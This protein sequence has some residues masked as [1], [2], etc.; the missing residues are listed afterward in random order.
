MGMRDDEPLDRWAQRR[1]RRQRPAGERR[2][3]PLAPGTPRASHVNPVGPRVLLEW[4][5]YSWVPVGMADDYAGE[6]LFLEPPTP[7]ERPAAS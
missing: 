5:G 7:T 3:V 6:R 4:D 1:E 2:A